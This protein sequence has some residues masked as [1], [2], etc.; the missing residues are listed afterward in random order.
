MHAANAS[1]HVADQSLKVY[2]PGEAEPVA[3]IGGETAKAAR[4]KD[5][6]SAPG[7]GYDRKVTLLPKGRFV[8]QEFRHE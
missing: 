1:L 7:N 4:A 3:P 5:L 8:S 2:S 6:V